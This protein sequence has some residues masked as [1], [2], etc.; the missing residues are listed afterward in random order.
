MLLWN[1]WME[2]Y[3]KARMEQENG[4][5]SDAFYKVYTDVVESHCQYED[6]V[7]VREQGRYLFKKWANQTKSSDPQEDSQWNGPFLK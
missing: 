3:A 5:K 4:S 1:R 7:A 6:A 2:M